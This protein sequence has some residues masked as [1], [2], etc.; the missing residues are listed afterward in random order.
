MYV[1][2]EGM[3]KPVRTQ[4]ERS[5]A[6]RHKLLAVAREHL[7]AKGFEG[8]KLEEVADQAGV[9]KGALYHHFKNKKDLFQAVFELIEEEMCAKCINA[10]LEAGDDA[11]AA[12]RAGVRGFLEAA[13]DPAAQRIV[14]LEG[15]SVLGW[16]LWREI[17]ERFGF[18][19]TKA[20]LQSA[21]AAGVLKE[22]PVDPLAHLFLAAIS[23]A[24]LQIARAQ[25]TQ[26]E[27]EEMFNAVMS[28]LEAMRS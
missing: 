7:A 11:W 27:M 1:K 5:E 6:T 18:G 2:G 16:D 14:L 12:L 25:D 22:R 10:A 26:A 13:L 24:A 28:I 8:T 21:M 23:E 4:A 3:N 20:S 17:D 9:T 15:P 19:L